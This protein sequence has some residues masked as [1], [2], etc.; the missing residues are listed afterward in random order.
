MICEWCSSRFPQN[1]FSPISFIIPFYSLF[2]PP[3]HPISPPS[4]SSPLISAFHYHSHPCSLSIHSHPILPLSHFYH[5]HSYPFPFQSSHSIPFHHS[6]SFPIHLLTP[7]SLTFSSIIALHY[8][9]FSFISS[10][11]ILIPLFCI[12]HIPFVS[13]LRLYSYYLNYEVY[14]MFVRILVITCSF[15]VLI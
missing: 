14:F 9:L 12:L 13:F 10:I 7:Y 6:H 15:V 3:F 8:L 5:T 1:S 11:P 4:P 2:H